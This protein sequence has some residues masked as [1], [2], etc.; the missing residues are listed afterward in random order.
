MNKFSDGFSDN[1]YEDLLNEYAGDSL[2]SNHAKKA[3]TKKAEPPKA[4]QPVKTAPVKKAPAKKT[5][6][7]TR[8][9]KKAEE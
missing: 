3:E 7:R 4:P 8:K 9:T 6:T 2:G 1:S 5:A